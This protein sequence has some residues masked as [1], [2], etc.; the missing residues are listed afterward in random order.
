MKSASGVPER[1]LRVLYRLLQVALPFVAIGAAWVAGC[2]IYEYLQLWRTVPGSFLRS[3]PYVP[4]ALIGLGAGGWA[5]FNALWKLWL[6]TF[7][8]YRDWRRR[9]RDVRMNTKND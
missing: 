3:L 5:T 9:R 4:L 1:E 2:T 7:N 8:E 6:L